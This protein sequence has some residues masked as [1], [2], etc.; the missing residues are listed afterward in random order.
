MSHS[1]LGGSE[2]DIEGLPRSSVT[3]ELLACS[4][5]Q[6][7]MLGWIPKGA[8][9]IGGVVS[10]LFLTEAISKSEEGGMAQGPRHN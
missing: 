9:P 3:L 7:L 6:I 1:S 4:R 2:V 8:S 10:S 5:A